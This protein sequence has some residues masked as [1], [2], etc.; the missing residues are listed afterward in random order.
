MNEGKVGFC[1]DRLSRVRGSV[2][3]IVSLDSKLSRRG[4]RLRYPRRGVLYP[5]HRVTAVSCVWEISRGHQVT[6]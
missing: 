1:I 6:A 2:S 3:T 5:R 4:G